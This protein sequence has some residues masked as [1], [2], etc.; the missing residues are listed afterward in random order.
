MRT[1]DNLLEPL[2]PGYFAVVM[3][4]EIVSVAFLLAHHTRLSGIFWGLGAA[5]YVILW[6]LYL[7][8]TVRFPRRVQQDLRNPRLTF[9][10]F[11]LVAAS[12]VL[13]TR[14]LLGHLFGTALA[15]GLVGAAL[16]LVLMYFILTVLVV[17]TPVP[18][19][20]SV[21]GAWLIAIVGV[22]SIA[23]LAAAGITR[24][25]TDAALLSLL[26]FACW[27]IGILLYVLFIT[28]ILA[29]LIFEPVRSQD[30]QPPYWINMGATAISALAGA[31]LLL[32][33]H[34]DPFL[35]AVKPFV[36]GFT[37]MLWAWGTWWIPFLLIIGVWKYL[38]SREPIRY[39][40]SLWSVV[41]P[42]GMYSAATQTFSS[43]PGFSALHSLG[44]AFLWIA[45]IAWSAVALGYV[46][47]WIQRTRS[48]TRSGKDVRPFPRPPKPATGSPS[49]M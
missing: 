45:L 15:L 46:V 39:H 30:M 40:P 37:V 28:L 10:Y 13:G 12:C 5:F 49:S 32:V 31:R 25:P 33:P 11:T 48:A 43:L 34:A 1:L 24:L 17:G 22:E 14:F 6:A 27:S 35:V 4:T 47:A 8:R 44:I 7:A 41:F 23:A 36:E 2:Y 29:R 26:A 16:W 3:A 19:L 42:L 18:T 21:N 20:R 38:A 9:G